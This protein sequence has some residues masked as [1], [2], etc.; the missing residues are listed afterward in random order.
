MMTGL[1]VLACVVFAVALASCSP[2][3]P[4]R[5]V[6]AAEL[7]QMAPLKATYSGVVMGFDLQGD[8][9]L[10]ASLDLQSFIEMDDDAAT[11]M[12]HGVFARWQ[13][14]WRAAHPHRH[15]VVR[16]RFIDFI[17]RRVAEQSIKL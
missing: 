5:D 3:A 8:A 14:V 17:G 2:K 7:A 13:S 4:A 9:T 11:A 16:V 6:R 10:I 15:A 12:K 1:R